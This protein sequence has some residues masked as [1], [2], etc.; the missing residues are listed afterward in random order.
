MDRRRHAI[1]AV[2]ERMPAL[3]RIALVP[4]LA[5]FAEAAGEVQD[6]HLWSI[7]WTTNATGE[8]APAAGE[9]EPS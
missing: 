5:T 2:L 3:Q 4:V 7:G 8:P 6:E 9:S 1:A